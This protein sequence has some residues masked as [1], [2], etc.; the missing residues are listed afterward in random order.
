MKID[1][2]IVNLRTLHKILSKDT[3]TIFLN[4]IKLGIEALK[5]IQELRLSTL[6]GEWQ[7]LPGETE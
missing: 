7:P 1:E 3:D 5:E 6:W 2:A 4:A